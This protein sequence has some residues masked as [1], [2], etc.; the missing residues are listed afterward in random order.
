MCNHKK[1]NFLLCLDSILSLNFTFKRTFS[2]RKG[3]EKMTNMMKAVGSCMIFTD[4]LL[5][6]LGARKQRYKSLFA[7]YGTGNGQI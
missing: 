6:I 4:L 3:Q 1:K 7:W 2:Q 5:K